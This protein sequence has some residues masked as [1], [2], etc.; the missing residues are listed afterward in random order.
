MKL[1]L[2]VPTHVMIDEQVTKVIAEAENGSF[3][4]LPRHA[5]F[6]AALAPGLL[7]FAHPNGEER[8]VAVDE[9]LLVKQADVVRVS[10]RQAVLGGDLGELRQ[11]VEEEFVSLDER[12][13]AYQSAVASL[14][15]HF[16]RGFLALEE[17]IA[18]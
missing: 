17:G 1:H 18:R 9:G 7:S 2:S 12:Q 3:C 14:E 6:L 10:T 4:V 13:R 15:A 5:D 8:F 16:L 11:R